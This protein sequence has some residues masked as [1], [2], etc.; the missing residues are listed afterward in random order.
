MNENEDEANYDDHS[1]A[2]T[3]NYENSNDITTARIELSD[4]LSSGQNRN[5]C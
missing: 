5:S 3:C 2:F 1:D 4:Y